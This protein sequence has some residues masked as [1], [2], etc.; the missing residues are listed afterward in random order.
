M[1][2][3]FLLGFRDLCALW[4]FSLIRFFVRFFNQ[5]GRSLLSHVTS[6]NW[7]DVTKVVLVL[8]FG[9]CVLLILEGLLAN[10]L[11]SNY[12]VLWL[13]EVSLLRVLSLD[14]LVWSTRFLP[15]GVAAIRRS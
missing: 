8:V 1:F 13:A 14:Q 2:Y 7:Y 12:E 4:R 5:R 15:V 11:V 3:G 10:L 9:S 6:Y